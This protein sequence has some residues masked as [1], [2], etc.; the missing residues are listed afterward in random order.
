MDEITLD[1][2]RYHKTVTGSEMQPVKKLAKKKDVHL[3]LDKPKKVTV[4]KT[5][6]YCYVCSMTSCVI[7]IENIAI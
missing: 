4:D 6:Y 1:Q 5:Y 3:L 2:H 7:C